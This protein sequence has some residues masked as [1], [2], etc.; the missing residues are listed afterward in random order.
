MFLFLLGASEQI[1]RVFGFAGGL[2]SRRGFEGVPKG[3]KLGQG[4]KP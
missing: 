3:H 1:N 2:P 4:E